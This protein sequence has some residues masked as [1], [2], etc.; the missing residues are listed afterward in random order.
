MSLPETPS[1]LLFLPNESH[2]NYF[3]MT[4]NIICKLNAFLIYPGEYLEDVHLIF[5]SFKFPYYNRETFSFST[6]KS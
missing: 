4:P 1:N 2:Q 3:I 6:Q 5:L